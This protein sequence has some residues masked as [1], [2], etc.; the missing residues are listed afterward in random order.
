[1]FYA[2]R[3]IDGVMYCRTSPDGE[4]TRKLSD[5]EAQL[6]QAL[7]LVRMSRGWQYLSEEARDVIDAALGAA[8]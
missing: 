1:M 2:E 8:K 3:E 4:W 6:L 5:L 7:E